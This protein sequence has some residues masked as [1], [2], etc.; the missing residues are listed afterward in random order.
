MSR[1]RIPLLAMGAVALLAAGWGGLS[2]LGILSGVP[3]GAA[4]YH[5]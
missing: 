4:T 2:R 1:A 5:G 3:S